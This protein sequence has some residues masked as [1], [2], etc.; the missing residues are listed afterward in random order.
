ME[1]VK[2]LKAR[3]RVFGPLPSIDNLISPIEEKETSEDSPHAFLG[4][5]HEIVG[6][7]YDTYILLSISHPFL[8]FMTADDS[9]WTRRP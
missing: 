5:D 6:Q 9:S 8:I 7:C 1:S 2:E 3:K 4:G